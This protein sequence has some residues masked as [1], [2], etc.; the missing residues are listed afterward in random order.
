MNPTEEQPIPGQVTAFSIETTSPFYK[1]VLEVK[2]HNG[3]PPKPPER[4]YRKENFL[5]GRFKA[6]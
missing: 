4:E 6:F 3:R 2:K 1:Q 5:L